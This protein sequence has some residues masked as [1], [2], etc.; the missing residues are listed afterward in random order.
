MPQAYKSGDSI[1]SIGIHVAND[2]FLVSG[3]I[4][5]SLRTLPPLLPLPNLQCKMAP[6]RR[7]LAEVDANTPTAAALCTTDKTSVPVKKQTRGTKAAPA[8]KP[9][10]DE[11]K[12]ALE[13]RDLE[14][15]TLKAQVALLTKELS[16]AKIEVAPSAP[17]PKKNPFGGDFLPTSYRLRTAGLPPA[18]ASSAFQY[19]CAD[20]RA[21]VKSTMPEASPFQVNAQLK[22]LWE[23]RSGKEDAEYGKKAASDLSRF[24]MEKIEYEKKQRDVERTNRAMQE[25][26][27]DLKSQAAMDM[28]EREMAKKANAAASA[29]ESAGPEKPKQPRTA[30]NFYVK[31]RRDQMKDSEEP[32]PTMRELNTQMSE[33]WN[34]LQKSKKKADKGLHK[35]ILNQVDADRKRYDD[36]MAVYNAAVAEQRKKAEQEAEALEKIALQKYAQKEN[37][38]AMILEGK[39]AQAEREKAVKAEKKLIREEKKAAREAKAALPKAARTAYQFFM[40]ENRS[41]IQ[42]EQ[43]GI[44]HKEIMRELGARWKSMPDEGRAPYVEHAAQ[45]RVRFERETKA[46]TAG[47]PSSHE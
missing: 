6:R 5:S 23:R 20:H 17:V 2:P 42:E 16:K 7:A 18:R 11:L 41:K 32:T 40:M 9:K 39:R 30:W 3:F 4:F 29:S 13:Q 25:M 45:D 34:K 46:T 12:V 26:Q 44:T 21:E 15:E 8:S 33:A 10:T 22:V 27:A 35:S 31:Y 24:E 47:S 38:Q 36:E 14:N 43:V 1:L 19:F 28:Y 37:E